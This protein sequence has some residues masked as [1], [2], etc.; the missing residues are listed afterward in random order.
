MGTLLRSCS[1]VRKTMELSFGVVS[2]VG[3][4]IRVLEGVHVQT[5]TGRGFGNFVPHCFGSVN[6]HFQAK[7]A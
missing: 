3:L 2:G 7:R 1:K 6:R 4:A 5:P